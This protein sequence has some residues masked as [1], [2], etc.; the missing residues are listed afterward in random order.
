MPAEWFHRFDKTTTRLAKLDHAGLQV[1]QRSFNK[2]VFLLVMSQEVMPKRMLRK[3]ISTESTIS[4][5]TKSEP[6]S[7]L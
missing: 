3:N 2:V 4:S 1:V 5:I 6:C 7:R